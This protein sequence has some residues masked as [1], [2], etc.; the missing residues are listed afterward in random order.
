MAVQPLSTPRSSDHKILARRLYNRVT[1]SPAAF[2]DAGF[3]FRF[4]PTAPDAIGRAATV[5]EDLRDE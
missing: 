5:I 2:A 4:A 3:E 1:S